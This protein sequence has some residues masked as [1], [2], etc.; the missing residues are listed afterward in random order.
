MHASK[1]EAGKDRATGP[2]PEVRREGSREKRTSLAAREKKEKEQE[3][4]QRAL[5]RERGR[6]KPAR[7]SGK[8]ASERVFAISSS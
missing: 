8:E 4:K 1:E 7:R 3:K 2:Q 6:A 5:S